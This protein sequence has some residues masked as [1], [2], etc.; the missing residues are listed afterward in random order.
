MGSIAR[1]I[2]RPIAYVV[3]LLI[4]YLF[5][6]K[7]RTWQQLK[8]QKEMNTTVG[9]IVLYIMSMALLILYINNLT[10]TSSSSER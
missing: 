4:R 10:P 3:G 2:I 7:F 6:F 5:L 9:F 8:Q 1:I